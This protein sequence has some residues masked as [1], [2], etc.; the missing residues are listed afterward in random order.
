MLTYSPRTKEKTAETSI[1][2]TNN[3][4]L[5]QI[6]ICESKKSSVSSMC[7]RVYNQVRLLLRTRFRVFFKGKLINDA[8]VELADE[9][10]DIFIRI[11]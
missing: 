6:V 8:W 3:M 1:N 5:I 4:I 9:V 10:G 7:F 2:P 11:T